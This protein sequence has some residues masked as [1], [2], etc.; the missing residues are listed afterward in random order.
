MQTNYSTS[1]TDQEKIVYKTG[2]GK[3]TSLETKC[4]KSCLNAFHVSSKLFSCQG[5]KGTLVSYFTFELLLEI[6]FL[7]KHMQVFEA[8][9]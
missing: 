2:Q 4:S 8:V 5:A 9:V 7:K 6:K 1:K 3:K